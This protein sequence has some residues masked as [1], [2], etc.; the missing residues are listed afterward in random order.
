MVIL[1]SRILVITT[2]MSFLYGVL[3]PSEQSVEAWLLLWVT[4]IC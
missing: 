1:V 3:Y 4:L 2:N